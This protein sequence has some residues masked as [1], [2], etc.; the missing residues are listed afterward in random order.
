MYY[1]WRACTINDNGIRLIC[2]KRDID[3]CVVIRCIISID[4]ERIVAVSEICPAKID[5]IDPGK[6]FIENTTIFSIY[7]GSPRTVG[8]VK[9]GG[10]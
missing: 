6:W 1:S 2:Y 9:I 10:G 7:F 4:Y 3:C 8:D 5:E